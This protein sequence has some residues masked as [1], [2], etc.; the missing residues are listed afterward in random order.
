MDWILIESNPHPIYI[1]MDGIWIEFNQSM[2]WIGLKII[3]HKIMD[4]IWID[5]QS[6]KSDTRTPLTYVLSLIT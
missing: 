1:C 3:I 5:I 4:R 2:D 6:V